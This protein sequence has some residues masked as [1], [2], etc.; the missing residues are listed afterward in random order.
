M[1]ETI[2]LPTD[3][4]RTSICDA[5]VSTRPTSSSWKR[6]MRLSSVLAISRRARAERAVDLVRAGVQRFGELGRAGVDGA[7]REVDALLERADDLL[8]AIGERLGDLHHARAE[9][10]VE[11]AGCGRRGPRRGD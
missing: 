8:A 3:W 10:V 2:A 6:V 1:R 7:G 4:P 11:G 5:T 9:R